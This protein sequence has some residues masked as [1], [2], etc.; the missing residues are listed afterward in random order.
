[1]IKIYV[2]IK[3]V[4]KTILRDLVKAAID[5]PDREVDEFVMAMLDKLFDYDA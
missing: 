1:M 3:F 4:Y 5:N 2:I